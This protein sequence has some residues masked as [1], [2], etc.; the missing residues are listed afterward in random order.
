MYNFISTIQEERDAWI[1]KEL[2]QLNKQIK[3][4]QDHEK[5]ISQDLEKDKEKRKQLTKKIEQLTHDMEKEK[6]SIDDHNK[7]YYELNK[8]KDQCQLQRKELLVMQDN[9]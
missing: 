8:A 2:K 9:I 1:Q 5:K 4:K 3:D 6:K 7:Q